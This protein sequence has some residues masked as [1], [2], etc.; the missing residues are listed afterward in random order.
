MGADVILVTG[1]SAQIAPKEVKTIEVETAEEMYNEV[2][3]RFSETD[4]AILSAAVS[5]YRPKNVS[6]QKIKKSAVLTIELEK[7]VDI[8]QSL[9]ERKNNQILVGFALETEN[10]LAYAKEKMARKNCDLI[11]MNTLEDKG[12]GF[13]HD[14]NKVTLISNNKTVQTELKSK[15][16]IARDILNFIKESFL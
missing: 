3:S 2:T 9:G 14:T 16:E 10:G 13:G 4:I 15:L 8:L 6:K 12:A 1:P 7:T 5:D 11:V